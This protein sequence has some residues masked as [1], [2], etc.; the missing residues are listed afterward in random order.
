MAY[1]S[2][3]VPTDAFK[4]AAG[5]SVFI[6]VFIALNLFAFLFYAYKRSVTVM[7]PLLLLILGYPFLKVTAAFNGS[8]DHESG[9]SVLSYNVRWFVNGGHTYESE[10]TTFLKEESPDVLCFQ[11]FYTQGKIKELEKEQGYRL[12]NAQGNN[13]LVIFS[14]Y[15]VLNHGLLF[16]A[17]KFNNILFADLLIEKDTLRVYNVHLKSMGINTSQLQDTDGIREGYEEAKTK[18]LDGA[19]V[20]A[21]QIDVLLNHLESCKHH[22]VIAGDFNDVPYSYNHFKLRRAFTNTFE[23][24]GNGFGITYNGR[25]P[26]LRIDHQFFSE[27]VEAIGFKTFDDI[28]PSD[29]FPILGIYALS[30]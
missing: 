14:K 20:R 6:P 17:E 16:E 13:R 15:P 12:L 10:V 29:H 21:Q 9:V 23:S 22:I 27:G 8:T 7:L 4:L 11:E 5:I 25:L 1:G 3:L 18:F 24:A 26:F 30:D 19:A 28:G 2:V